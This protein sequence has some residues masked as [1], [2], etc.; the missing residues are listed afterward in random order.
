MKSRTVQVAIYVRDSTSGDPI[1]I[2]IV[3]MLCR[4]GHSFR[5]G[6][7]V[8]L[9]EFWYAAPYAPGLVHVGTVYR[10]AIEDDR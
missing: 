9:D 4:D 5:Q 10:D 7:P 8:F 2:N 1:G 6:E 3:E